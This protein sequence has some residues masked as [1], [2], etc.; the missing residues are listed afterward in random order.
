MA[1]TLTVYSTPLDN[2]LMTMCLALTVILNEEAPVTLTRYP[3]MPPFSSKQSNIPLHDTLTA[4]S[5]IY[6]TETLIGAPLGAKK[7]YT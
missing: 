3:M 6:D 1:A 4:V 7:L 2:E 5:L